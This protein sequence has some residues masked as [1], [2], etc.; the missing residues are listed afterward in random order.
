MKL[1]DVLVLLP[2]ALVL[3]TAGR[4]QTVVAGQLEA[5]EHV[6]LTEEMRRLSARNTWKGVEAAYQALIELERKGETLTYEDHFLGAQAARGL[7]DINATYGRLHLAAHLDEQTEVVEWLADIDANY[8][9]VELSA[10]SKEPVRLEA[11]TMPFA[12]DKR[13]AI[14]AA[15]AAMQATRTYSGLLPVG[16]YTLGEKR[17]TVTT[18]SQ[19]ARIVLE[20]KKGP[21]PTQ[22]AED[23]FRLSYVGPRV[24]LGPALLQAGA[25]SGRT[26]S[27]GTASMVAAGPGAFS[28]TGGRFGIGL[29]A[30]ISE[31][32]GVL[33]EIGW[34]GG[35][36][37]SPTAEQ[38]AA[39]TGVGAGVGDPFDVGSSTMSFGYG[40]LGASFRA[41]RLWLSVGPTWSV[42]RL[43]TWQ[44]PEASSTAGIFAAT[45]QVRAG[46]ALAGASI[47]LARLGALDGAIS[48]HGGVQTDTS[49][50]YGWEQLG[51]LLATSA[52]GR[53]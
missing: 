53:K 15:A 51:F 3:G 52:P 38:V 27:D 13:A 32:F 35:L 45:G 50:L 18:A 4:I 25:P 22:E 8:G 28:T 47:V 37:S 33:A 16:D 44:L 20:G 9:P 10:R 6:R 21:K 40:W 48:L 42:G 43:Y 30:G 46:G 5:A 29:E 2:L 31:H 39:T 17:F 36:G 24:F 7:G 1:R 34:C 41:G 23:A 19:P 11:A 14:A 12:P 26:S 49:R